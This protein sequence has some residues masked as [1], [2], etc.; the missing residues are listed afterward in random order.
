M[1]MEYGE[2]VLLYIPYL[3]LFSS[4]MMNP[5]LFSLADMA[6]R[7]RLSSVGHDISL[8]FTLNFMPA[9]RLIT[10]ELSIL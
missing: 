3:H 4:V 10:W 6:Y 7:A 2:Y 5:L 9:I 1:G 8:G